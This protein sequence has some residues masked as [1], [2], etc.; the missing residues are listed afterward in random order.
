MFL[1]V[2]RCGAGFSEDDLVHLPERFAPYVAA[3]QPA[4]VDA[5]LR[6]D[7]WFEP[8][9]V[10]EVSGDELTLSPIHTAARGQLPSD[11]GLAI[12][13]PRFTGRWRDDLTPQDAIP[14]DHLLA[15]YERSRRK[16]E[17]LPRAT[18]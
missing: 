3:S 8:S 18:L 15:L 4:N 14:V 12:R 11:R 1:T 9:V 17:P 16:I 5:R 13:F 10:L 2:T 6:A 7:A